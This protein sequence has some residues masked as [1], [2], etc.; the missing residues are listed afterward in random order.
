MNN[1]V[2]VGA[3]SALG[4]NYN[5][6][7]LFVFPKTDFEIEFK[8]AKGENEQISAKK[9]EI[10]LIPPLPYTV[11]RSLGSEV[12]AIDKPLMPIK[13]ATV[14]SDDKNASVRSLYSMAER[15]FDSPNVLSSLSEL[16]ISLTLN[17]SNRLN[18]SPIVKQVKEDIEKNL[19]NPLFSIENDSLGKL[20]LHPNYI[21]RLFK[22]ETGITPNGYLEKRRMDLAASIISGNFQNKYSDYTISQIAELCG[23]ADTL[24]FS[25]VFKK[26]HGTPPSHYRKNRLV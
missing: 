7:F 18:E 20:P 1:I 12:V 24:Y 21:R 5:K 6:C 4:D 11:I 23:Y 10:M 15:Y 17:F 2:F 26:Y 13:C 8:N 9:G 14:F 19:S 25:R 16:L 3:F 22:S